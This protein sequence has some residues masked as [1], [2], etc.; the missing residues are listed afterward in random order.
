MAG[1]ADDLGGALGGGVGSSS[2]QSTSRAG[3]EIAGLAKRLE[4]RGVADP[5]EVA[6]W[7]EETKAPGESPSDLQVEA[8]IDEYVN[9]V[10]VEFDAAKEVEAA[11]DEAAK[12]GS[13]AR[14]SALK[15]KLSHKGAKNPGALAAWIGRR[16][17][18]KKRFQKMAAHGR[19]RHHHKH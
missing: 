2:N 16:K 19:K 17:Y 5:Q 3:G 10:I 8:W 12:V 4:S 7:I 15:S 18:G 14:F 6:D 11:I 9:K 1:L 13:G